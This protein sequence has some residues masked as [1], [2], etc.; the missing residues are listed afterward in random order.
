VREGSAEGKRER[1]ERGNK[2]KLKMGF[3]IVFQPKPC[4]LG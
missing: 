2:F 1:G 4:F 3:E